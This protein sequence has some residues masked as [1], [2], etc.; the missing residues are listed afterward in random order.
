LQALAGVNPT[1]IAAVTSLEQLGDLLTDEVLAPHLEGLTLA[2]LI[3]QSETDPRLL[4]IDLTA[5]FKDYA[6]RMYKPPTK[7]DAGR[8]GYYGKA[9]LFRR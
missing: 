1:L 9:L 2:T 7:D 8:Y 3:A 4:I 5:V 6:E